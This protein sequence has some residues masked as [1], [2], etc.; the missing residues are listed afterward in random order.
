MVLWLGIGPSI[1]FFQGIDRK[2]KIRGVVLLGNTVKLP[3]LQQ[4]ISKNLGYDVLEFDS[5]KE[6][7]GAAVIGSPQF[8]ENVLAYGVSYGLCLQGL[9]K[10][11][12]SNELFEQSPPPMDLDE[13][14]AYAV[15]DHKF[16]SNST[17]DQFRTWNYVDASGELTGIS[18]AI[19]TDVQVQLT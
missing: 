15:S 8:S 1:G 18:A 5:F 17:G 12:L 4:Y 7:Q 13:I 10:A 2:A 9:G 19:D 6:L 14:V 3:G 11:R 16:P